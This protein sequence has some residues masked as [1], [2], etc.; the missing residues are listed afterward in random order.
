MREQKLCDFF[1]GRLSATELARD[2]KGST[3]TSGIVSK[4]SIEDMAESFTVSSTMAVRLCDAV[5][6]GELPAA[7]LETI[8]FALLASDRFEWDGDEDEVL[9][10]VI[11]DWSAPE[12]NYPLTIENVKKFRGWLTREEP[13]PAKPA[14]ADSDGNIISVTEKKVPRSLFSRLRRR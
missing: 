1:E 3:S 12:I 5:L 13:Y 2:V 14:L 9:A 4:V 8:G 7:E 10:N 11:G 6:N